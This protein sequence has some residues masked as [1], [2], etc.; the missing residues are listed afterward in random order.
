MSI[1]EC[2]GGCPSL[3]AAAAADAAVVALRRRGAGG[4]LLGKCSC[5]CAAGWL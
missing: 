3:G 4:V 5:A 1:G 2:D